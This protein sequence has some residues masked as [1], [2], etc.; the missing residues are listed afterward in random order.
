M[1]KTT[2]SLF[3]KSILLILW[4]CTHLSSF[5]LTKWASHASKGISS[6]SISAMSSGQ[7]PVEGKLPNQYHKRWEDHDWF[8]SKN[9]ISYLPTTLCCAP[10][11]FKEPTSGCSAAMLLHPRRSMLV[12]WQYWDG[13]T[14]KPNRKLQ[15]KQKMTVP[16]SFISP[17]EKKFCLGIYVRPMTTNKIQNKK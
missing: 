7:S 12:T 4:K 13:V 8:H 10:S 15:K 16:S 5:Y 3:L 1:S 14:A 9:Y 11:V 6:S 2:N 17:K